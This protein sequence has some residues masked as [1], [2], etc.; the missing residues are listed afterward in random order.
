MTK[1]LSILLAVIALAGTARGEVVSRNAIETYLSE[2]L[3]EHLKPGEFE[4][5][6]FEQEG[7]GRV[8]VAGNLRLRSATAGTTET[9]SYR[10][11]RSG[12]SYERMSNRETDVFE[13]LIKRGWSIPLA[14]FVLFL[15]AGLAV[16][17]GEE[18]VT[19]DSDVAET[20]MLR[21]CLRCGHDRESDPRRSRFGA[22]GS[23]SL[24]RS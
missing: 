9:M 23:G 7:S 17:Q 5:R 15:Q 16:A 21:P 14:G 4:Y 6:V 13:T 10:K 18:C 22:G 24:F 2:V 8:S 19:L 20:R 1:V 3:P 12:R 11:T